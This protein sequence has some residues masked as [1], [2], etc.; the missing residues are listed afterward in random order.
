MTDYDLNV[1]LNQELIQKKNE[2][3][4]QENVQ[5]I[6]S[7]EF[8]TPLAT[9]L[10]FVEMIIELVSNA[11]CLHYLSLVKISLNLLQNLVNDMLDLNMI[12]YNKF[13]TKQEIFDPTKIIEFVVSLLSNQAHG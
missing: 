3:Q 10:C 6:I 7:H 8:K 5:S 12:K 13:A 1:R 9:A 2:F 11:Q 4:N